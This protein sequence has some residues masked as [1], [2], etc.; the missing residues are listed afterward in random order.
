MSSKQKQQESTKVQE[1][2]SK[3]EDKFW[4]NLWHNIRKFADACKISKVKPLLTRGRKQIHQ[5]RDQYL[6]YLCYL[7]SLKELLL[8]KQKNSQVL[9]RSYI[10][11]NPV[12]GKTIQQINIFFFEWKVF[13]RLW[14][15]FSDSYNLDWPPKSIWYD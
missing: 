7:K 10:T 13:K 1:T 9:I 8:I 14:W 3:M 6:Y 5:I 2:F 11:I 15:W 4:Q 12:L